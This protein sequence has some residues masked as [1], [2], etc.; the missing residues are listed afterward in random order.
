S[1]VQDT[2]TITDGQV[3]VLNLALE[4]VYLQATP[5]SF[6]DTLAYGT[7]VDH[8]LKIAN[9]GG[10]ILKFRVTPTYNIPQPNGVQSRMT[11]ARALNTYRSARQNN[12]SSPDG[13][14]ESTSSGQLPPSTPQSI[15]NLLATLPDQI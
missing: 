13:L 2:V 14:A 7:K 10:S 3:T 11:K 9:P 4:P 6:K 8:L 5:S 12:A 15:Q 1:T